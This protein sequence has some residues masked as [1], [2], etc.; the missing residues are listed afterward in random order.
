M[1]Y[2]QPNL[3]TLLNSKSVSSLSYFII[4]FKQKEVE[5]LREKLDNSHFQPR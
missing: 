2:F 1:N 3:A 5:N 4:S